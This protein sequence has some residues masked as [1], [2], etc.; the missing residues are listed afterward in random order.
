MDKEKILK[1]LIIAILIIF[2]II[3]C[4]TIYK[5]FIINKIFNKM[6]EYVAIDNYHMKIIDSDDENGT[7]EVYYKNG[8]GKYITSTGIYTWTDGKDAYLINEESKKAQKADLDS[9][10]FI[11]NEFVGSMVP[12][13]SK[14]LVQKIFLAGALDTSVKVKDYDGI[15][16]YIITTNENQKKTIWFSYNTLVPSQATIEIG[17]LK[18][19]YNYE[20]T[21]N[22]VRDVDVEKPNL[23]EYTFINEE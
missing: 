18:K 12:G 21:F 15:K 3:G 22:K 11:S 10:L 6:Q 14:T 8:I 2:F 1:I 20:I 9:S 5:F 7:S 16:Y 17:D 19:T 4:S 23:E 13:Y